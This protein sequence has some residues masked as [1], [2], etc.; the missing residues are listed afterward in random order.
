[1]HFTCNKGECYSTLGNN[2]INDNLLLVNEILILTEEPSSLFMS[3]SI[4]I[5]DTIL[6]KSSW[7]FKGR[8]I[9]K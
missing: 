2:N 7:I 3:S 4:T 6:D 1:M 9:N 8:M 5:L